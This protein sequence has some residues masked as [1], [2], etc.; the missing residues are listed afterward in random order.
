MNKTFFSALL[1]SLLA[2]SHVQAQPITAGQ[3]TRVET[4]YGTIEGYQ[5][6]SIF[7]FKGIQ[8][9]KAERFML[10]QSP[11]RIEGIRLQ[12]KPH[13]VV[14]LPTST[15]SHGS[16]RAMPLARRMEWN[17]PLCCTT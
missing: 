7:T 2:V 5:D 9:A 13:R 10:P 6:G 12:Q 3:H 15:S 1:A 8:Y 17:S 4:I 14:L 11:D 16:L